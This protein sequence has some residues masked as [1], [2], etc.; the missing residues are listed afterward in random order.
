MLVWPCTPETHHPWPAPG[1]GSPSCPTW[2]TIAH[3]PLPFGHTLGDCCALSLHILLTS[4]RFA[5]ELDS[6]PLST[7]VVL[8]PSSCSGRG[9]EEIPP[10]RQA[11]EG[12]VWSAQDEIKISKLSVLQ[13]WQYPAFNPYC[14]WYPTAVGRASPDLLDSPTLIITANVH[15]IASPSHGWGSPVL[16]M[17]LVPIPGTAK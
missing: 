10:A 5:Q 1:P 3:K 14:R 12:A 16:A 13:P 15:H 8:D 9:A 7:L 11:G 6:L 2:S 4:A 17:S